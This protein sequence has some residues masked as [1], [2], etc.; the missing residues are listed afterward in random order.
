MNALELLFEIIKDHSWVD[1]HGTVHTRKIVF[2]HIKEYHVVN[3]KLVRKH[4]DYDYRL[5]KVEY[6]SGYPEPPRR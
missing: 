4:K 5:C 1:Q 3:G 2:T 6:I